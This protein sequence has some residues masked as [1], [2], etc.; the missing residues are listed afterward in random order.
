MKV[1]EEFS[2]N[3]TEE[4]GFF[5]MDFGLLCIGVGLV[6]RVDYKGLFLVLLVIQYFRNR[7]EHRD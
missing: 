7:Y 1:F 3:Q 5:G 2:N 6:E 4:R